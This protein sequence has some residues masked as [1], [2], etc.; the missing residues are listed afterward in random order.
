M[1]YVKIKSPSK[2][3]HFEMQILYRCNATQLKTRG[4]GLGAKSDLF[5][6]IIR[7]GT[8]SDIQ[9]LHKT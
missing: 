4:V 9:G 7:L 1:N 6:C 2:G 8:V 5:S 3:N